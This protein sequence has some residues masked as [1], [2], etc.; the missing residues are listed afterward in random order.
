MLKKTKGKLILAL[1]VALAAGSVT[2]AAGKAA[3][4]QYRDSLSQ[5]IGAEKLLYCETD[6]D[7]TSSKQS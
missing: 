5:S 2:A 6:G 1:A 3:A 4:A 7:L